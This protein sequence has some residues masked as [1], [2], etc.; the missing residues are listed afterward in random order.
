M[1]NCLASMFYCD[2]RKQYHVIETE[3]AHCGHSLQVGLGLAVQFLVPIPSGVDVNSWTLLAIFVATVA[4][5][6]WE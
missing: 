1:R 5:G 6:F 2:A 4:G 3:S